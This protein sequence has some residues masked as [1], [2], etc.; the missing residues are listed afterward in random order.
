MARSFPEPQALFTP[1][2][3]V[4]GL[5]GRKMSKSYDNAI[6]LS[7]APDEIRRKC[8]R[9]FTDPTR[10]RRRAIRDTR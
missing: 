1:T 2:P 4:P 3:R 9:M 10:I 8:M 6:N 5:D 7:D